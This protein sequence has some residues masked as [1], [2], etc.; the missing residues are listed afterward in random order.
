MATKHGLT[1]Q[2]KNSTGGVSVVVQGDIK[3]VDRFSNDILQLAPPASRIKSIEINPVMIPGF[4]TFK[5]TGS[6]IHDDQVTEIS[7]DIAVCPECIGDLV[8]DPERIDYPFVNCTNCGPR[9]TIIES[10]PYDRPRTTMKSFRMCPRCKTQYNDILDR[11]F[12]AQPIA[13]NSCGPVYTYKDS[14]KT[15]TGINEILSEVSLHLAS[16]RTV[17]VKGMGGYHLMCDALNNRAVS[18]LRNKK[19]RDAKP[20]AVM[21][22]DIRAL[23]QYC[24]LGEPEEK[25]LTSWRR[26]VLILKQ[27]EAL[28]SAVSD[29]LNTIGAMLPYMPVHY[30]LFRVLKTPVVVLTSGNISD[31]PIITSDSEAEKKLMPVAGSILSYNRQILNR[32]DDSVIRFINN[33]ISVIR[34]S[35]GFVPRPV[36]L[37][38]NVEGI[39]ALGAEQKNSFCIGRGNQAV[40]SQYIGDLKN[41]AT[42]DFLVESIER[43]IR[44]FRF[45]PH[46]IACDLHPDYLSTRHA[47]ALMKDL[48]VP[49]VRIQHHH[50]HIASCMAE[51]GIDEEVIG[52]SLDGTG[53]GTDGKI[54]GGEFLIAG[55]KS[56]T[57]VAHFDYVA[58]PG[59]DK[60]VEE[61]WRT[62]YS[63][64]YK[65]FGDEFDYES[66]PLFRIVEK[67][68]LSMVRQALVKNINSPL[69][70]GAGRLFDAVSAILGLCIEARFDSEAPMRLESVICDDTDDFYPFRAG[71]SIVFADTLRE[72][73]KDMK[74]N[75]A[76]V[77]SAKFHNT[78]AHVILEVSKKIRKETTLNKVLLSGGVFQNKYL[79][80]KTSYL[81][82]RNRFRIFT[83]HLVPANDGGI[84]LGQLVIASKTRT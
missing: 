43:F 40:M 20:F 60:A 41:E 12:H 35:R 29:G 54:W 13:C 65:Y 59:G 32:T 68:K 33:K 67:R 15:L 74:K 79:L 17:A 55:L 39:I 47:E 81:L 42:Y 61:T 30:M 3:T 10:L 6:K 7:P 53:F 2:V 5:I 34:R 45:R 24:I 44:L 58:L 69:S 75:P 73:I 82:N 63:Y 9:F 64:I 51:H 57:R 25:E 28:A 77:I 72:I 21:F 50:A 8:N 71:E 76:S 84:S 83:N 37:R 4:D 19:Q 31:E 16:G 52:V 56:F 27:K 62:A 80:E 36:D 46:C 14:V 78:I 26:P 18:E 38:F 66:M 70:S 48:K 49:L 11:R 1:G 22:R 23:K